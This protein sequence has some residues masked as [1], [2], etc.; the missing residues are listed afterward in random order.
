MPPRP[1]PW[2]VPPT[3]PLAP[4]AVSWGASAGFFL[5][6]EQAGYR[7][8]TPKKPFDLG[9]K[10]WGALEIAARYGELDLDDDAFP[11]YA[12]PSSSVSKETAVGLGVNWYLTKQVKVSVNYEHTTF[13]GGAADGGDRPSEDFVVTRFQHAF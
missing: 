4:G 6:G 11:I 12:N 10:T 13:E 7:S 5:T 9:E 2:G 8:P 1:W 3:L